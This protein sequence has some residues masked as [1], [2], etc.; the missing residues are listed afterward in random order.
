MR[1]LA[2]AV[3]GSVAVTVASAAGAAQP[4][5]DRSTRCGG[6]ERESHMAVAR[7]R[8]QAL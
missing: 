6:E 2:V 4:A 1:V 8:N 3:G 7:R 5:A